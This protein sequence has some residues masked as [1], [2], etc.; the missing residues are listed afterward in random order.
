MVCFFFFFLGVVYLLWQ[1]S[2]LFVFFKKFIL[3]EIG[4]WVVNRW[5]G[6][7]IHVCWRPTASAGEKYSASAELG[8]GKQFWSTV[9]VVVV[10]GHEHWLLIA[11]EQL[12]CLACLKRQRCWPFY[13][14]D[15]C[16]VYFL[17]TFV[18]LLFESLTACVFVMTRLQCIQPE[19]NDRT[20]RFRLNYLSS[21]RMYVINR[22]W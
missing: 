17:F 11:R 3:Y 6:L 5:F 22:W 12:C 4:I 8:Q 13:L 1:Q 7:V 16:V 20:L 2:L 18:V 15:G 10:F 14:S 9:C 21:L 19:E